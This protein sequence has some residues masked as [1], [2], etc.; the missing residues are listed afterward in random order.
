MSY[1][2][3]PGRRRTLNPQSS[4]LNPAL[5]PFAELVRDERRDGLQ[6]RGFVG[7]VGFD[8]D[9]RALGGGKHHYAHDAFGV[10]SASV[11]AHPH[12]RGKLPGE[13]REF[14]R[15]PRVQA[16]PVNDFNFPLQHDAA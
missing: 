11:A 9:A 13:L 15:R 1:Y 6:G 14:R 5:L 10:D 4:I 8:G 16:E 12:F 2:I 7:A 3:V